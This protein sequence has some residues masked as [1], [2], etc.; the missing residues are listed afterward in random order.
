VGNLG[1]VPHTYVPA[2]WWRGLPQPRSGPSRGSSA[3]PF[4]DGRHQ[5]YDG[6]PRGGAQSAKCR[7]KREAHAKAADQQM[8]LGKGTQS[9]DGKRSQRL[10]RS[11]LPAVHEFVA[12]QHDGKFS[13]ATHEPQFGHRNS[14]PTSDE[15]ERLAT[16]STR[17]LARI[18]D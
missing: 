13:T 8:W 16:G 5:V 15:F 17:W 4:D 3:R 6:D 14:L 2:A 12:V 10:L 11:A 7:A 18:V 1:V 9:I